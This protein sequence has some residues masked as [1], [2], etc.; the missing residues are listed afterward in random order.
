MKEHKVLIVGPIGSFSQGNGNFVNGVT[1]LDVVSQVTAAPVGTDTITVQI[2]SNGGLK[3]VGDQIYAYLVSLKSK[4]QVR[5][6]QIGGIASIATKIFG[7]GDVRI[8]LDGASFMIHNPWTVAQGDAQEM[9]QTAD[10]LKVAENELLGFYVNL[11]GIPREGLIPLLNSET[12]FDAQTALKLHFATE[13]QTKQNLKI[14]AMKMDSRIENLLNHFASFVSKFDKKVLNMVAELADGSKLFI[15]TSDLA[16]LMEAGAYKVDAQGNPT[17]EP[18]ADGNYQLKDGRTI[19]ISGG[20]I[21][22]VN[23]AQAQAPQAQPASNQGQSANAAETA[24]ASKIDAI[25]SALDGIQVMSKE[26]I[27]SAIDE[28]FTQLRSE[29]KV[30]HTPK[31]YVPE[32]ST[33]DAAEWDKAFKENRIAAMKKNDV[34]TYQRL[35]F[36]KY[37]KMPNI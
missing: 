29:L 18:A 19:T 5:T 32:N 2:E 26:E 10:A 28:R 15:E 11:T 23:G 21:T 25:L 13:I 8:A 16:N 4:Y 24:M 37:G 27:V 1:L 20:M 22:A 12:E 31:G 34:E 30:K 17:Q 36:A 6:E 3:D 35:F 33:H 7:A 9:Q 14:A